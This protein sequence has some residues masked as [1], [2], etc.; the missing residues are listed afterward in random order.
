MLLR[1]VQRNRENW[2]LTLVKIKISEANRLG[3]GLK[4]VNGTVMRRGRPACTIDALF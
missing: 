4:E 2:R 3:V 1:P